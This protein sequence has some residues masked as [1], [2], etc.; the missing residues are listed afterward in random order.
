M[1]PLAMAGQAALD[2]MRQNE[3]NR[4]NKRQARA[5]IYQQSASALGA[6]TYNVQAARV[7][8][9]NNRAMQNTM[10]NA[11]TR[12]A[13]YLGGLSGGAQAATDPLAQDYQNN[14]QV[15]YAGSQ[16]NPPE[17]QR[18]EEPLDFALPDPTVPRLRMPGGSFGG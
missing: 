8:D 14:P 2:Y 10:G 5:S 18:E 4:Q 16:I 12:L 3:Q 17:Q 15:P 13:S 1:L 6:P 7:N 11:A 9:Q